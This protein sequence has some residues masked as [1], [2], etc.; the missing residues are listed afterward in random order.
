MPVHVFN[1]YQ[2]IFYNFGGILTNSSFNSSILEI[3]EFWTVWDHPKA[4]QSDS[5]PEFDWATAKPSSLLPLR[6][7]AVDYPTRLSMKLKTD[8]RTFSFRIFWWRIVNNYN[9]SSRSWNNGAVKDHL[10]TSLYGVITKSYVRCN[11]TLCFCLTGPQNVFIKHEWV[12]FRKLGL[13][14]FLS[15]LIVILAKENEALDVC[16]SF[17]TF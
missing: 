2:L 8:S 9:K 10:T 15:N 11:K 13:G 7:S 6:S 4:S 1:N 14:S 5:C 12:S 3:I 17:A 16:G